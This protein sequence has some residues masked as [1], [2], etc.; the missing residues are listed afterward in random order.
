LVIWAEAAFKTASSP[1]PP[2]NEPVRRSETKGQLPQR[3]GWPGTKR[4]TS[5]REAN[6]SATVWTRVPA[7]AAGAVAPACAAIATLTGKPARAASI[8]TA[9][10]SEPKRRGGTM[11]QQLAVEKGRA[12]NRPSPPSTTCSGSLK[13]VP[14]GLVVPA[15]QA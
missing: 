15:M 1:P 2:E 3:K 11:A 4:L 8:A 13:P 10:F 12:R 6:I 5:A 7:S 14:I 9:L